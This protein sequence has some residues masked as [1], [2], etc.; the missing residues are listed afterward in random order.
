MRKTTESPSTTTTTEWSSR[1]KGPTPLQVIY[2]AA[3]QSK[4]VYAGTVSWAEKR[5]RRAAN[6]RA[7]LSR[8]AN[9]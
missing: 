4:H 2:L 3:L 6:K 7:R 9:R 1:F 8:K 5:R